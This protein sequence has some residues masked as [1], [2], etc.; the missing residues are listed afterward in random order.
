MEFTFS[1]AES[2]EKNQVEKSMSLCTS[3]NFRQTDILSGRSDMPLFKSHVRLSSGFEKAISQYHKLTAVI[4]MYAP[5]V[6]QYP[7]PCSLRKY[8]DNNPPALERQLPLRR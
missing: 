8:T 1:Q 7:A 6:P 4:I 5:H 2:I 3:H